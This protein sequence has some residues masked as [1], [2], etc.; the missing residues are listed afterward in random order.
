MINNQAN[1]GY[2][3]GHGIM[4]T[5]I[6][7]GVFMAYFYIN[8]SNEKIELVGENYYADGQAFQEKMN[9]ENQEIPKQHQVQLKSIANDHYMLIQLPEGCDSANMQFFR[10]SNARLD[11]SLTWKK[12]TNLN[13]TFSTVFLV[14]GPWKRTIRWSVEGKSYLQEDRI[15]IPKNK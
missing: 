5:F 11:K 9:Q 1:K 13:W 8:M 7:F 6:L 4:V 12:D 14:E 15:V 2:H 10:P 3:W